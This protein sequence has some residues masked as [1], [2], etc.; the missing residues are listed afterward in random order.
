MK[1]VLFPL[2]VL[3]A[4][5]LAAGYGLGRLAS[6]RGGR[7]AVAPAAVETTLVSEAG[8]VT[9]LAA[10]L[11]AACGRG[12][13]RQTKEWALLLDALNPAAT[14]R[15]AGQVRHL[16]LQPAQ[17]ELRQVLFARWAGGEPPAAIAF[18]G[19][20]PDTPWR[21]LASVAV[22][23]SWLY[24]RPDQAVAGIKTL[25]AGALK[26]E[27][28]NLAPPALAAQSPEAAFA[29][30]ES[31]ARSRRSSG[32]A[33]ICGVWASAYPVSA[34]AYAL[35]LAPAFFAAMPPGEA[36]GNIIAAFAAYAEA[37]AQQKPS[38]AAD[39]IPS[40]ADPRQRQNAIEAV[41]GH[42]L[43]TNRAAA[44]SWLRSVG[45]RDLIPGIGG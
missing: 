9:K 40:I 45:A 32:Y 30:L 22:L 34:A 14:G 16:L 21:H 26:N 38:L 1:K 6:P 27:A 44:I 33:A 25:P 10:R 23:R 19:G 29:L 8:E 31:L 42:W 7:V 35:G 24:T 39:C 36:Q 37:V 3:P 43:R 13:W 12:V 4:L 17:E 15:L 5:L 41:A 18:V 20:L 28:V 2:C 11:E